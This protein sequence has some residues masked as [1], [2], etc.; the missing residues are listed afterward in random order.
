MINEFYSSNFQYFKRLFWREIE[1]IYHR[2]SVHFAQIRIIQIHCIIK[3][4]CFYQNITLNRSDD[5]HDCSK[6]F[7][8][9]STTSFVFIAD[10]S[11]IFINHFW[12]IIFVVFFFPNKSL[13]FFDVSISRAAL[14]FFDDSN[15]LYSSSKML[16]L[17]E[18]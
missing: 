11:I 2:F 16:L 1:N 14:N 18:I 15:D 8:E 4:N 17:F 5:H 7:I 9:K 3:T 6:S 12:K 13:I 10:V